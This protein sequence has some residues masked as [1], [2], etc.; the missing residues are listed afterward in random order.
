MTILASRSCRLLYFEGEQ[1]VNQKISD[2]TLPRTLEIVTDVAQSVVRFE[3][4]NV[5]KDYCWPE[6]SIRSLQEAGMA[7]LVV[8]SSMG[9]MGLGLYGLVQVCEILGRECASTGISF[10]MHCVGSSVIGAQATDKQ[11]EE[12]L[13]PICE[14]RHLTTLALSEPGTGSHF[15]FPQL[16][17][18]HLSGTRYKLDGIKCFVTNGS[19]ADSYVVSTSHKISDGVDKFSCVIVDQNSPGIEWGDKWQGLGMRGNDSRLMKIDNVVV[20]QSNLLGVEGDQTWYVFNVVAPYFLIAMTGV[21]LGIMDSAIGIA[22]DHMV[23]RQHSH[24]QRSLADASI[25]QQRIGLLWAKCEAVRRLAYHAARKFDDGDDDAVI[26]IMSSK[27]EV[28]DIGT[29]ILNEVMTLMGGTAFRDGDEIQRKFRDMRA[30][31]VM[32]PTTD[33]LRLWTG[34]VLLDQPMLGD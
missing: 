6:R 12:Y 14:G 33:L 20:P 2:L 3:A 4:G 18:S 15:Y 9:G 13:G 28:A 5:D 21:Y 1:V 30:A 25:L 27:A 22:R 31:H 8:P 10:G 23:T 32:A 29:Q 26:A 16:R 7:G 19:H 34:R 17:L 11:I 24:N